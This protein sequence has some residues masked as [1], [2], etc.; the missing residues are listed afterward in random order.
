MPKKLLTIEL[1]PKTCWFS[2]LRSTLT[3]KQWNLVR[4]L[5]YEKA[6]NKCEICGDTGKNQGYKHNVECHEIWQYVDKTKTQKLKGLISLCPLCHKA[7]HFGRAVAMGYEKD[8]IKHIRKINKWSEVQMQKHIEES[9][10][11]FIER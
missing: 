6:D 2:N 4:K 8:I 11:L 3:T 5:S 7:K 10:E 1:I 9:Y